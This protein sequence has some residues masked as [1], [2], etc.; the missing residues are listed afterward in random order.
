MALRVHPKQ[1]KQANARNKRHGISV[2][3][4]ADGTAVI[5]DR[6]EYKRLMKLE[7]CFDK[8]GFM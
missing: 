3:Y 6:G 2:Q 4:K 8:D 5:P 7:G 1:V